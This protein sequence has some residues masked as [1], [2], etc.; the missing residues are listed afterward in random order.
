MDSY[1]ITLELV[2]LPAMPAHSRRGIFRRRVW[3]NY[4][5]CA[6]V[7]NISIAVPLQAFYHFNERNVMEKNNNMLEVTV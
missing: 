3:A 6:Y 2:R 7:I 1:A 4:E 5:S